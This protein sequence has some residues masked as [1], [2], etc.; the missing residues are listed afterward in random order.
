MITENPLALSYILP[1]DVYIL[2]GDKIAA[3][4]LDKAPDEPEQILTIEQP[5][6]APALQVEEPVETYK[7]PAPQIT[8]PPVVTATPVNTFNYTGG[9]QNKFLVLVHYPEH[10]VMEA[11]HLN[12]LESTIKRK[13]LSLD[14]VAI[15]NMGKYPGT[16]LRTVG[17]FFK[18]QQMLFLGKDAIPPGLKNPLPLNQI[19][20]LG[21]CNFLYTFSFGE[22]MGNKDNTKAFWEQMKML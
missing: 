15:V 18:P 13:G 4:I 22:M 8:A 5:Q 20:K 7:A 9:Y 17:G 11:A 1:S 16:D 12:A 3:N 10:E 6:A 19:I 2:P 14:D 21:N